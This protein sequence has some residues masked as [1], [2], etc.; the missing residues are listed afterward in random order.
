MLSYSVLAYRFGQVSNPK[1]SSLAYHRASGASWRRIF[2]FREGCWFRGALRQPT[3]AAQIQRF[4]VG[5][6]PNNFLPLYLHS[7]TYFGHNRHRGQHTYPGGTHH[8]E[9]MLPDDGT[10]FFFKIDKFRY[11]F[12][13]SRDLH[14]RARESVIC[15]RDTV[16]DHGSERSRLVTK[17]TEVTHAATVPRAIVTLF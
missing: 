5:A 15:D 7:L 10:R 12:G 11:F 13:K 17:T 3:R 14:S 9:P 8:L 2:L 16:S 1:M 4:W 6:A